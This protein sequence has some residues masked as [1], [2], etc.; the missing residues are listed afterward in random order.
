MYVC[1]LI[2]ASN[3]AN[4]NCVVERGVPPH[5]LRVSIDDVVQN[6]CCVYALLTLQWILA[7]DFTKHVAFQECVKKKPTKDSSWLF[8]LI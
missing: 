1:L 2:H 7:I 8:G 6:T 4:C 5:I 3:S